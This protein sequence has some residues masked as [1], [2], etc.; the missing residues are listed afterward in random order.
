MHLSIC[1]PTYNAAEMTKACFHSL[2]E[3]VHDVDYEVIVVDDLSTDGTRD[4][5]QTLSP[6]FRVIY[7]ETRKGF[8]A[9]NNLAAH[10]ARGDLLCLLNCDTVL[11]KGWLE[12]ML[13]AFE[14]YSDVGF[15]GNVQWSPKTGRYDHM[16][17][18]VGGDLMPT[19]FGRYWRFVPFQGYKAWDAVTAA[20]VLIRKDVFLN[21]DGFDEA[22]LNGC[23][24]I[25]LCLKLDARGYRHYVAYQSRIEHYV[26]SSP[27]RNDR[28]RQ[29]EELFLS[30]WENILRTKRTDSE[31]RLCGINYLGR[32]LDRPWRYNFFK[33]MRALLDLV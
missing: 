9:N 2:K 12:P 27:G 30:R 26:S 15:V 25:D 18:L 14:I 33:L 31:R 5:L 22:Y 24:D 3:T 10:E 16:G 13:K 32:F 4:Y 29:N 8:A 6:P 11:K 28:N 23:E 1:I 21:E 17:M 19:H 20:C 7:N